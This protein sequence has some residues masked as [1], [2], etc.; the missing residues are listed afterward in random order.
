MPAYRLIEWINQCEALDGYWFV[1]R[2]SGNDTQATGSHQA[3]PYI[4]KRIAFEIFPEIN[5]PNQHN[6]DSELL[7]TSSSHDHT[8]NA[9]IIWYNGATR[10][11]TRITRLGGLQS[12]LLNPENT[13]AVALLFFTGQN[14]Q[15]ECRYWVCRDEEQEDAAESFSGPVE[16][17]IPLF[18]ATG[19]NLIPDVAEAPAQVGCWLTAEEVAAEWA[20][21]F[22][23][24]VEVLQKAIAL[25]SYW[26]LPIDSRLMRRR[27]CEYGVFRSVEQAIELQTI[28]NGF[29]S[30][31]AFVARA[32]TILQRRKA[33][34]GRSLEL[35]VKTILSEEGITH[36]SQAR[37]ESGN[38][39]D[40][41][42]PSQEAYNNPSYPDARLR[43]LAV[44]TTVKER[45]RQILEEADRIP[46]KHLLTLQEGV[47][48]QQ[49]A[50]MRDAGVRL[51]VPEP[52]HI[53]FPQP[54]RE[55]IMTLGEMVEE[56]RSL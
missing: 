28:Q 40:F 31:D 27:D 2:L 20:D 42:F 33:R 18:W 45:W 11:E 30:V 49:F 26:N 6:P 15:R 50:Q 35:H 29:D 17:G 36:Q 19:G 47:S 38:I 34:S 55:E 12:P 7:A 25:N 23:T 32:N 56:V 21:R 5:N 44:K 10:D 52:L 39:P 24:P 41:L 3:G 14:G 13:G 48:E 22:P 8:T 4:P 1:K 43:M 51:V 9:R 46:V 37:T 53:R 16:P 54:I